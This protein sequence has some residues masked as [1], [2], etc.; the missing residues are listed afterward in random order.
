MENK[1]LWDAIYEYCDDCFCY[2]GMHGTDHTVCGVC[3]NGRF[4]PE[5]EAQ[6][7]W[8]QNQA[9]Q[10]SWPDNLSINLSKWK[11]LDGTTVE[12]IKKENANLK[13]S[14]GNAR[15]L[16]LNHE[17]TIVNL[18]RQV[19]YLKTCLLGIDNLIEETYQIDIIAD[20]SELKLS[21]N[22]VAKPVQ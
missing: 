12:G 16:A 22:Y 14:W 4:V 21:E 9:V 11:F 20:E 6:R 18:K 19:D 2:D 1:M 15:Q 8:E 13:E 10:G 17:Q 5:Q 7:L 3:V